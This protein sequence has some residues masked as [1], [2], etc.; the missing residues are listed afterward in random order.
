LVTPADNL[1]VGD[2]ISQQRYD[3]LFRYDLAWP[4]AGCAKW[5]DSWDQFPGEAQEV[6]AHIAFNLNV[7]S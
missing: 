3:E 2:I 4:L 1:R 7:R 5:V 6:L